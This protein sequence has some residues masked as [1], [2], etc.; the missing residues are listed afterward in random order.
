MGVLEYI[1]PTQKASTLRFFLGSQ[2]QFGGIYFHS[3]LT[4]CNSSNNNVFSILVLD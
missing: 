4:D 1:K 2:S 3:A